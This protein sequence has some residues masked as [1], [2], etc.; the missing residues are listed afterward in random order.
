M[1]YRISVAALFLFGACHSPASE[2]PASMQ[3][4][5]LPITAN[6]DTLEINSKAAV[7]YE[8]D[9]TKIAQAKIKNETD[10]YTATDDNLYYIS[11]SRKFLD[12]VKINILDSKGKK[13]LKFIMVNN[14]IHIVK[15]DTLQT[16]WGLYL[17]DGL[18]T[19]VEAD[20]TTVDLSYTEYFKK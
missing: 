1:P 18:N 13:F 12:S 9:S 19:P 17:F 10:F 5:K 7:Y 11:S 2:Q 14:K 16:L 4:I 6:N 15:T 20:M 8:P 3:Q